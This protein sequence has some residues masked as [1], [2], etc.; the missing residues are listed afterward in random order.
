VTGGICIAD[1]WSGNCVTHYTWRDP[2]AREF[3]RMWERGCSFT[4]RDWRE[5]AAAARRIFPYTVL[6][7]YRSGSSLPSSDGD[8]W[9]ASSR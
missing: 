6:G 2:A 8:E 4:P 7:A 5:P 1:A 9:N 3:Y